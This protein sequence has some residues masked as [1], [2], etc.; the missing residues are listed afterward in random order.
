MKQLFWS[1]GALLVLLHA[2]TATASMRRAT[3]VG[4]GNERCTIE[5]NVDG[6][7]EIEISGDSGELRTISGLPAAWRRFQC[8]GPMPQRPDDFRFVGVDGRGSV[9]LIRDPRSN[10][11]RALVRI[12]DP[13]GGREGYTFD[14]KW[15]GSGG[16]WNPAP[17]P[18]PPGGGPGRGIPM[19]SAI[20]ACQ[21][22]VT[23]RLN[24]YG[25]P[26]VT[27]GR[28]A[29][30][31]GPGRF[32]Q[33]SGTVTGRQRFGSKLFSFSCSVDLQSGRVQSLDVRRQ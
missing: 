15:R 21:D 12:D 4:G 6:S 29:P 16:G 32:A 17:P 3:I 23:A 9:R 10:W 14:L 18:G 28:T 13:Q 26:V 31:P 19:G 11:G 5:I 30:D 1:S 27:F 33:V 7:A 20:R 25:Y 8:T 22:A 24:Q 2:A